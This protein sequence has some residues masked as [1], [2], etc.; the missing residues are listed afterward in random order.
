MIKTIIFQSKKI[1][2]S[3]KIEI[4]YNARHVL[5]AQMTVFGNNQPNGT[6]Q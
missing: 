5:S 4:D 2:E 1:P 6:N 3:D